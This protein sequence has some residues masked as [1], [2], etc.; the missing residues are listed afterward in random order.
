MLPSTGYLYDRH[1][2]NHRGVSPV[3]ATALLVALVV[4]LATISGSLVIGAL[5][6][7]H[8]LDPEPVSTG[9]GTGGGG[10]SGSFPTVSGLPST[11]ESGHLAEGPIVT[12]EDDRFGGTRNYQCPDYETD[13]SYF[14]NGDI[15]GSEILN[16][17]TAPI[18]EGASYNG[19]TT[20]TV[21]EFPGDGSGDIT[22]SSTGP[23]LVVSVKGGPDGEQI[24]VFSEP[25]ILDEA[26]F[27]TPGSY[28]ISNVDVCCPTETEGGDGTGGGTGE[29]DGRECF[30]N[31]T[32]AYIGFE[33]WLPVDV[34]NEVQSDSVSFDLGFYTEQCRHNDGSGTR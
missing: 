26:T 22:L 1:G 4:I 29:E 3:I 16:P 30:P 17:G 20:I 13:L 24:Y 11:G 34:G 15:V 28:D 21:D 7:M 9:G 14:D 6:G 23:V 12:G 18:V 27:T 5:D 2:C 33:W 31:S 19:C 10:S 8:R 32:T 25:V